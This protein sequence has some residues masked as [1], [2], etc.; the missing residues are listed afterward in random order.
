M[1]AFPTNTHTY[2]HTHTPLKAETQTLHFVTLY[3][4]VLPLCD[5]CARIGSRE[6]WRE[7]LYIVFRVSIKNPAHVLQ[8]SPQRRRFLNVCCMFYLN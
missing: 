8:C 6:H 3:N 5:I 7:G 1:N 4:S 2:T